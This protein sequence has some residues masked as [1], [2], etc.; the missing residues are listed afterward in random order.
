VHHTLPRKNVA[1]VS[2]DF[3]V[4]REK[5]LTSILAHQVVEPVHI[6]QVPRGQTIIQTR[7]IDKHKILTHP[8]DRLGQPQLLLAKSRLVAKGFQENVNGEPVDSPTAT[9]EGVR[10]VTIIAAHNLWDI[11]SID[12]AT[13]FLQANKRTASESQI[14]I[15]PPH[16]AGLPSDIVW[17]L[18]KSLYGLRS[19]PKS[20]WLSLTNFLKNELGFEQCTHDIALFTL[21]KSGT[22]HGVIAIHVDDMLVTGDSVFKET[23]KRLNDRFKFGS[24][25]WKIFIHLGIRYQRHPDGVIETSQSDYINKIESVQT[26]TSVDEMNPLSASEQQKLRAVIGTLMWVACSTRPDIS[27][28]VSVSAAKLNSPTHGDLKRVNKIVRYLK[29]TANNTIKYRKMGNGDLKIIAFGDAA[30]QNL[31]NAGTQGGIIIGLSPE[32]ESE[33]KETPFALVG[34]KS[35]KI[36]RVVTSTF[37]GELINQ[38]ATFD[39]GSHVRDLF[40]EIR[41][42]KGATRSPLDLLT[43]CQSV[44][45]H[46]RS[47]RMHTKERRLFGDVFC[48]REAIALGEIRSIS[49]INTEHMLADGLTKNDPKLKAMLLRAMAGTVMF[50]VNSY[51]HKEGSDQHEEVQE[52]F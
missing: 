27:V 13:A 3:I 4:S 1:D 10:L 9:K 21:R 6:S 25:Q 23:L 20:W 12:I 47:L 38:T 44:V 8:N 50:K 11:G 36:R 34:Y 2:P 51:H 17:L 37:S 52:N 32:K 49:H 5:E 26:D 45:D 41:K 48:L 16:E 14:F 46:V 19:A 29:G 39:L 24:E 15:Q 31:T 42:G 22:L 35:N 33:G 28:D 30:F 18:L 7:W 40:D 43:D